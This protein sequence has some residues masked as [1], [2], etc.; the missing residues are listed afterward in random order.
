MKRVAAA[1]T[2]VVLG[3]V[4]GVGGCAAK[5][6]EVKDPA[7]GATYYTTK[8]TSKDGV[9]SLHDPRSG[10]KIT[11]QRAEVKKIS[12]KEYREGLKDMPVMDTGSSN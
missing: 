4:A 12:P 9:V 10:R 6:W 3:G 11:V 5:H 7:S 2:I 8:M 1:L